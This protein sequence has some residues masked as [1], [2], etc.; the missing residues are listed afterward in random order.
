VATVFLIHGPRGSGKTTAAERLAEALACRGVEVGGFFQRTMIDGSGQRGYDLVRARDR[1]QT[2][3]LARRESATASGFAFSAPAFR[4][5][6]DWLKQDAGSARVLVVDEVG[7]L[8]A[9][10]NGHVPAIR[11]AL[12]LEGRLLLLAV[13]EDVLD[14]VVGAL[15]IAERIVGR[16]EVPTDLAAAG[17]IDWSRLLSGRR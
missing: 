14:R 17:S 5:G 1:S 8:E 7:R 3:P 10:G 11:W 9:A 2:L 4:A 15:G 12:A 6:F 16:L 13:R